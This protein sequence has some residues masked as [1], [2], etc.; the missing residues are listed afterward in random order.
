MI[1]INTA[2]AIDEVFLFFL[3][4]GVDLAVGAPQPGHDG[5]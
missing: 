4:G 1:A 2:H 5:A 3:V